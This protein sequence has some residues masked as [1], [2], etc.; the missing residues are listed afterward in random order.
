MA[1][2]SRAAVGA[3]EASDAEV[4]RA[5][6]IEPA[7]L[8]EEYVRVPAD[9]AR[10]S[11]ARTE[12]AR[13]LRLAEL[14]LEVVESAARFRIR[15]G[16]EAEKKKA[17]VDDLGA[18]VAADQARQDAVRRVIEATAL[19]ERAADMVRAIEAKKDMLVSLG[20]DIRAEKEGD[21][22]IRDRRR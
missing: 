16:L 9:L 4:R 20:A 19:K 11:W 12:A 21:P 6:T 5:T 17:T 18:M 1:R 10:W 22:S 7:A 15:D 8:Q 13:A 14:D 3:A 2:P